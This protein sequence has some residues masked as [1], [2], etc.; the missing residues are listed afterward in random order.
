MCNKGV[1]FFVIRI[2]VLSKARYNNK[3]SINLNVID[4]PVIT[5]SAFATYIKLL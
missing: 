3:K 5:H 4:P 1:H 2:S